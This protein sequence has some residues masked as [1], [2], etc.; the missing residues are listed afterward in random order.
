MKTSALSSGVRAAHAVL[1]PASINL[2]DAVSEAFDASAVRWAWAARG[3]RS[4]AAGKEHSLLIDHGRPSVADAV[5]VQVDRIGHHQHLEIEGER[6]LRL[7]EGDR[8]VGVFGNRY[9]TDVYEGRVLEARKLHLLTTSGLIG[10]VTCRNRNVGR[11]TTVKFVGFLA[12]SH[13]NRIN[14]KRL[15]LQPAIPP[16]RSPDLVLV[17]GTGM[18]TGKTTVMRKIL[19]AMA[20]SGVRVAGCKL[21]GT[22]SPRDLYEMKGT[23]A[24]LATD[25]SDYGFPST[26]GESVDDLIRLMDLMGAACGRAGAEIAMIEIADGLLQPETQKLLESDE[27]RRRVRGVVVAG[28]CSSSLLFA[29]EYLRKIGHEVWAV[30]GLITNSPLFVREFTDRSS[31]VVAS[32]RGSANRLARIIVKKSVEKTVKR[33]EVSLEKKAVS[34]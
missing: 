31:I 13:G 25:F 3:L 15:L 4:E 9:A 32:S 12:D 34:L 5:V 14:T 33:A 1:E 10:T 21:T 6:R 27:V 28:E 17:V 11:P 24:V 7:Y 23:G 22:A 16:G 29:T 8:L 26:Y 19:R 2:S 20:T 30:S 18:S